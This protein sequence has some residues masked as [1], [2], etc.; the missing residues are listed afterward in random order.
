MVYKI[1]S[2]HL[3]CTNCKSTKAIDA[4]V[5]KRA[6]EPIDKSLDNSINFIQKVIDCPG[7]GADVEF[8]ENQISTNC[9][10]CK[11]PLVTNTVNSIKPYSILPFEIDSTDAKNI[12]KNWLGSLWFAPNSLKNLLDFEHKFKAQYIPYFSFDAKSHSY[13]RGQRGDAYYIEVQ[14]E[15][16]IDG[17]AQIITELERHINWSLVD[18]STRRD[19][20]DI[21]V[22]AQSKLPDI[23][24]QIQHFD[25]NKLMLYNPCF[26]SGYESFEYSIET[27]ECY[28]SA[29]EYMN[30]IIYSDVL[31]SIGG[32]EQR[33]DSINSQFSN[34]VFEVTMLPIWLSS[35]SHKNRQY[36]IAINGLTGEIVGNRPYSYS[37]I[38][39]TVFLIIT[40]ILGI[41][42]L[43]EIVNSNEG[44]TI[45][46]DF[47]KRFSLP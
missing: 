47:N 40:L 39:I 35:F 46:T 8:R 11:T 6:K 21:L 38:F 7:C 42:Y 29:K 26:L 13:Y 31:Y 15:V 25:L 19:F 1:G 41:I 23:V 5:Y 2:Y 9:P 14:R 45:E 3:E 12:F 36:D 17:R 34:E 10:Y 27:K 18:G 22:N 4:K 33:V 43:D 28:K 16:I 32:D 20:Y 30:S 44:A 24:K 37:K